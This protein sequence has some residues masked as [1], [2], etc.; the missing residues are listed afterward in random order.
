MKRTLQSRAMLG[1][2]CLF[3]TLV[4][5]LR[6]NATPEKYATAAAC[7]VGKM[8][9]HTSTGPNMGFQ[10]AMLLHLSDHAL[11]MFVDHAN[12]CQDPTMV[13]RLSLKMDMTPYTTMFNANFT[14][15]PVERLE[16]VGIGV[17]SDE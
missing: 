13:P 6:A 4:I 2:L 14:M 12:R 16:P 7:D 9:L 3:P 10:E 1:A 11:R 17:A 8:M 5:P 15:A